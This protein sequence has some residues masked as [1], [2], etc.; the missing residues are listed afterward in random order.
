MQIR[1]EEFQQ[2]DIKIEG[3]QNNLIEL[4]MSSFNKINNNEQAIID[5]D[6]NIN[7]LQ[8][9]VYQLEVMR[10]SISSLIFE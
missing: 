1:N 4:Q 10:I 6:E 8:H 2:K 3:L 5:R 7:T 9:R